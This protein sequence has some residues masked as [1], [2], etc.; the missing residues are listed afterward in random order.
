MPSHQKSGKTAGLFGARPSLPVGS[1]LFNKLLDHMLLFGEVF[2]F[3]TRVPSDLCA[4]DHLPAFGRVPG[5]RADTD[6]QKRRRRAA[7]SSTHFRTHSE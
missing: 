7:R 3:A 1:P 4:P 6:G 2:Y 5:P